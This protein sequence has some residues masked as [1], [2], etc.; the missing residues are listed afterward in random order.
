[1]RRQLAELLKTDQSKANYGL[2]CTLNADEAVARG[3]ALQCAMLSSRLQTK[4][5]TIKEAASSEPVVGKHTA[6]GQSCDLCLS[7]DLICA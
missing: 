3:V 7:R 6:A 4:Q 1:M 5:F 2:S